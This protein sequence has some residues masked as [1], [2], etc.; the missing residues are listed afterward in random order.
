M[1]VTAAEALGRYYD[2]ACE[3]VG[4]RALQN[5]QLFFFFVVVVVVVMIVVGGIL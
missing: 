1:L 5:G 3:C 4:K 2:S